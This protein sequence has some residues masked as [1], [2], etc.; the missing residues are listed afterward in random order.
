MSALG[1]VWVLVAVLLV[2]CDPA[3]LRRVQL[4]LPPAP[5]ESGTLAIDQPDVREALGIIDTVVIPLGFRLSPEQTD[6]NY[7]R[8]YMLSRPPTTVEGRSYSRDIPVRVTKTP[9]GMEVAFGEFGFLG[10]T[11]EV[12]VRAFKD[13]RAAFVKKY[14][15]KHVRTKTFGSANHRVA[16]DAGLAFCPLSDTITRRT[17]ALRSAYANPPQQ[18][19]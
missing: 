9:T 8:V 18:H 6:H 19:K 4:R 14:G 17:C 11:P 5:T 7:I 15:N 2:G 13:V 12:A 1:V 3:G 10:G 16:L